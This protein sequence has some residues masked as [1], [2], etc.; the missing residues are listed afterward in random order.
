MEVSTTLCKTHITIGSTLIQKAGVFCPGYPR[1]SRRFAARM[2]ELTHRGRV[3]R[4]SRSATLREPTVQ[5]DKFTR[6]IGTQ[7]PHDPGKFAG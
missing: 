1:R 6:I 5:P 2:Y 7:A 4:L 3:E